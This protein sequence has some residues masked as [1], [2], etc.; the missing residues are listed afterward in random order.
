MLRTVLRSVPKPSAFS[1]RFA[2][3]SRGSAVGKPLDQ[4]AVRDRALAATGLV[5]A[6]G[7]VWW[8][9]RTEFVRW[10]PKA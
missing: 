2:S 9:L 4:E 10:E 3:T 8:S 6:M 5:G 7:A 1:Q